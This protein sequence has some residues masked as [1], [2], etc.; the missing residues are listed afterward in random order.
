MK[1]KPATQS[2]FFNPRALLGFAL[3]LLGLA[4]AFF[5][6]NS[7]T[8]PSL[9]AQGV[10][11][12]SAAMPDAFNRSAPAPNEADFGDSHSSAV[13]DTAD[14]SRD[15]SGS[16]SCRTHPAPAADSRSRPGYGTPDKSGAHSICAEPNRFEF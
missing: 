12:Q 9:Q 13:G 15:G 16:R 2:A 5:A 1:K 4:L 10:S 11:A 7:L 3:C 6:V 8:G 14:S